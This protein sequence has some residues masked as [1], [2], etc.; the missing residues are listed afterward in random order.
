M[1]ILYSSGDYSDYSRHGDRF[2]VGYSFKE[3]DKI[4]KASKTRPT[5]NRLI[6]EY[7][8][9]DGINL[10]RDKQ[11][12]YQIPR[13]LSYQIA[14]KTG[15]KLVLFVTKNTITKTTPSKS[16]N[17][18]LFD[19]I[20]QRKIWLL[21]YAMGMSEDAF[22][23]LSDSNAVIKEQLLSGLDGVGNT[24]IGIKKMNALIAKVLSIRQQAWET[25]YNAIYSKVN[26]VGKSEIDW[27]SLMLFGIL[28]IVVSLSKPK[29]AFIDVLLVSG[30]W[31]GRT[32]REWMSQLTS[33]DL[34]KIESGIR[35]GVSTEKTPSTIYKEIFGKEGILTT[36]KRAIETVVRSAVSYVT[37]QARNETYQANE[38]IFQ[39]ERYTAVLDSRTSALCRGLDGNIY[40]VG[41][42]PI[43]PMHPNCRSVRIPVLKA[44]ALGK[45]PLKDATEAVYLAEYAKEKN[46]DSVKSR[47]D[48]PHGHK[49]SFDEYARNR[50]LRSIGEAPQVQ[51]YNDW[52]ASQP[53][54]FVEGVLG[55]Q[56]AKLFLQGGI[57]LD[58]HVTF[59]GHI[60]TL[61][62][63]NKKISS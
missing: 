58:K 28:P 61:D 44:V 21:S 16:V 29:K 34:R 39:Y 14:S 12:M 15:K 32:L 13:N 55:V 57:T 41:Q 1:Q 23:S 31:D 36:T 45:M 46:I 19:V 8:I 33:E 53:Q 6:V 40:K 17:K 26:S 49:S 30:K 56:R 48:L 38:D 22:D 5:T 47:D 60:Y 35:S 54:S 4:I 18:N 51:N 63:L 11:G 3:G 2:L 9:E 25:S 37:G 24:A 62:E 59:T 7:R 52:L 27:V 50:V 42:G 20:V 43:P 10:V